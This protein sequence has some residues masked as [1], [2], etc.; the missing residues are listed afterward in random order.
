MTR[1]VP[2]TAAA[3][4]LALPAA[5]QT[6]WGQSCTLP[7][8]AP[9]P[10]LAMQ[11]EALNAAFTCLQDRINELEQ[12]NAAMRMRMELAERAAQ[13]ARR[14]VEEMRELAAAKA[15]PAETPRTN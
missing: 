14:K 2:F 12:E 15:A 5:A 7:V 13:D 10:D 11:A 1:L 9:Q 8:F 4:A 6:G 3:F